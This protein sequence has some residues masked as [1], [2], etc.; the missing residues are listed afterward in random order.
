MAVGAHCAVCFSGRP[1]EQEIYVCSIRV[2]CKLCT[3]FDRYRFLYKLHVVLT[4]ATS[5]Q[6]HSN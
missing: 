1:L 5:S 3:N 4:L 2:F 6:L